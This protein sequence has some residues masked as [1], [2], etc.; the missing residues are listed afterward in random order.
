MLLLLFLFFFPRKPY[1]SNYIKDDLKSIF[2]E[3]DLI[4]EESKINWVSKSMV[5]E[6]IP[7]ILQ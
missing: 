5:L 6:K 2:A 7:S 4:L 3:H 1:Y